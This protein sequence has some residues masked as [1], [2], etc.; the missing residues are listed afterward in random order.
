M[1][2]VSRLGTAVLAV[3]TVL[4]AAPPVGA[5][6]LGLDLFGSNLIVN[7]DAESGAASVDGYAPVTIPGWT[8]SGSTVVVAYG[9]A[10]GFPSPTDPGPDDRG[11]SFFAGGPDSPTSTASQ[12][13]NVAPVA[14]LIDG[15]AVDYTLA[16]YLGGWTDQDDAAVLRITFKQGA[17]V[18][19]SAEIG[20]V[21]AADRDNATGL[22][23]RDATGLVPA[24]TRQIVVTLVMTIDPTIGTYNDGYADNLS[25]GLRL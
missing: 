11:T 18:L 17:L 7:G 4:A 22:L 8:T 23:A 14:A 19:G 20:P 25:L 24:G 5:S 2:P 10:G 13:I 21:T 6:G 9:T 3:I 12:V 1:A 16:G 15:G